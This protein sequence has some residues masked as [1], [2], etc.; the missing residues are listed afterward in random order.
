MSPALEGY[1]AIFNA[2]P[3]PML[4][5][6][7][8]D[9]CALA[10]NARFAALTGFSPA[11]VVERQTRWLTPEAWQHL[12]AATQPTGQTDRL[13][14][15][16]H[17][18]AGTLQQAQVTARTV[19]FDGAPS[20]LLIVHASPPYPAPPAGPA[21]SLRQQAE[22]RFNADETP[23]ATPLSPGASPWELH[24]LQVHQIELEL[25]NEELRRAQADL[26]NLHARYFELYDFAPVGYLTLGEAGLIEEANLTAAGLLGVSK[27]V[28]A[29]QALARFIL[30]EDQDRYYLQRRRLVETGQPQACDLRLQRADTAEPFAV[31]SQ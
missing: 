18:K 14:L 31:S 6:R 11:E 21:Q 25:Q 3:D 20:L 22:A 24:E 30:P 26:E 10:A 1:L 13:A 5:C 8:S 12:S 15:A 9:G 27:S 16:V 2:C 7:Q 17:T 28:L 23:P 4:V 19:D 29:Q